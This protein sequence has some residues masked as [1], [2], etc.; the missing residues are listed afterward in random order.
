MRC[1]PSEK[2]TFFTPSITSCA[3]SSN[4]LR[5]PSCE[6]VWIMAI[7]EFHTYLCKEELPSSNFLAVEASSRIS[8]RAKK[9]NSGVSLSLLS[10]LSSSR[11]KPCVSRFSTA[12]FSFCSTSGVKAWDSSWSRQCPSAFPPLL[13][14]LQDNMQEA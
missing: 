13:L 14:R 3:S 8:L 12:R 7:R 5:T 4:K 10:M 1:Q 11:R 2:R 6:G 9:V